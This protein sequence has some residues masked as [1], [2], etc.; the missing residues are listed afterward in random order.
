MTKLI[1]SLITEEVRL[2]F[3]DHSSL[4]SPFLNSTAVK[5]VT[6]PSYVTANG[7]TLATTCMVG[8][9]VTLL[10]RGDL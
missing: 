2:F 6:L 5:P 1:S 9:L 10:K 8:T 7:C 4:K 3:K